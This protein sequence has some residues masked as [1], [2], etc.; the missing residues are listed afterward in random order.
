LDTPSRLSSWIL[1]KNVVDWFDAGTMR[2]LEFMLALPGLFDRKLRLSF[3]VLWASR[4]IPV[5]LCGVL[6]GLTVY[7]A[8]RMEFS[9]GNAFTIAAVRNA[10]AFIILGSL[11][12]GVYWVR[13]ASS[14]AT[15]NW[16][17]AQRV[18]FTANVALAALL[19]CA[20]PAVVLREMLGKL[21]VAETPNVVNAGLAFLDTKE[22]FCSKTYACE[23]QHL[24]SFARNFADVMEQDGRIDLYENVKERL[25]SEYDQ[26]KEAD[27]GRINCRAGRDLAKCMA[28]L[29]LTE[30]VTRRTAVAY[31]DA[32]SKLGRLADAI[33][34]PPEGTPVSAVVFSTP[35]PL[36]DVAVQGYG[37]I[38]AIARPLERLSSIQQAQKLVA[39]EE[40][41]FD[42]LK[43]FVDIVVL[44]ALPVLLFFSVVFRVSDFSFRQLWGRRPALVLLLHRSRRQ[45]GAALWRY[46]HNLPTIWALRP[47]NRAVFM[48]LCAGV[49]WLVFA[50]INTPEVRGLIADDQA[51]LASLPAPFGIHALWPGIIGAAGIVL[52]CP[53]HSISV[54]DFKNCAIFW[55]GDTLYLFALLCLLSALGP[56]GWDT[57]FVGLGQ[58]RFVLAL[59]CIAIFAASA[60]LMLNS[61]SASELVA[62]VLIGI[63]LGVF[64][65][66]IPGLDVVFI[67]VYMLLSWY[68]IYNLREEADEDIKNADIVGDVMFVS[69]V[70]FF[71]QIAISPSFLTIYGL[72]LLMICGLPL[73]A[74]VVRSRWFPSG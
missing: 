27:P 57:E 50:A 40:S 67:F 15:S 9:A 43:A 66:F 37:C 69:F 52:L 59:V 63:G 12:A 35:L 5:L 34:L 42:D 54:A 72:C 31:A 4:L 61:R 14:F 56:A 65:L 49:S 39:G 19:I 71:V 18:L 58:Q 64:I 44:A 11:A 29:A 21:A 55:L 20:S 23:R 46:S 47:L 33:G 22:N 41:R 30:C 68:C 51:G 8:G 28:E 60:D 2:Y 17:V 10:V 24:P 70:A 45:T 48:L 74:V 7:L 36:P 13:I 26:L 6:I 62:R 38:R 53:T 73:C 25:K 32:R 3:P 16:S 1:L